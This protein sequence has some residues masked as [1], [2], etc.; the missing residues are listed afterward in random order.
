MYEVEPLQEYELVSQLRFPGWEQN[1]ALWPAPIPEAALPPLPRLQRADDG[2]VAPIPLPAVG[3]FAEG[4]KDEEQPIDHRREEAVEAI[5][6]YEDDDPAERA[7]PLPPDNGHEYRHYRVGR[8]PGL[9]ENIDEGNILPVRTRAQCRVAALSIVSTRKIVRREPELVASFSTRHPPL[10]KTFKDAMASP[11]AE[12]WYVA[13]KARLVVQSF[14]P[15]LG[16]DYHK[17]FAPVSSITTIL[18]VVGLSA[19]RGLILEQWS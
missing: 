19:A 7:P 3:P 6:S 10:S 13:Y 2:E 16:I 17:T 1:Q 15:R 12:S 9:L 11:E 4:V 14:A 5:D 18:F 8:N